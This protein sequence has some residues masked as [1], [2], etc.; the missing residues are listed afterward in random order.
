M[1]IKITEIIPRK[2]IAIDDLS[3]KIILVDAS[4]FMYQF[5]TTV[6]Q[7]DGTPLMDSHGN[8][9]S[10]LVGIFARTTKLMEKGL[11]LAYVFDGKS[12]KLKE[13]E[14][15]RRSSLK[16]EAQAKYKV[17]LK[18]KDIESMKKYAGRTARLTP[19]MVKECK[20]LIEALGLPVVQSPSEAEAQAA[21][22]VAKG[23]AYALATQDADALIFGATRVVRNLSILGKRKKVGQLKYE[24]VKPELI[25][26]APTLNSLGIDQD[27]L[28][29]L[30]MLV[31]TDFNVGGIHGIGPKKAIALV[32]E[33][34]KD[35][36]TLF[37][38]V[39][40]DEHFEHPWTEV[41]YTIKKIPTTD[42]YQ[43]K[44]T[45]PDVDKIQKIL[46]DKHDF[47]LER[48]LSAIKKIS[49]KSKDTTQRGLGEWS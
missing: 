18:K 35:F 31:G 43:L 11:K 34:G 37:E 5:L 22:M 44:W 45:S 41:F 15:E 20:Q 49:K 4:L 21:H 23:K 25:E 9:T 39:H 38:S 16:E 8:I 29:C 32:K 42:D 17:A 47:S 30:A 33:H 46:V 3:G 10:H 27:Q 12:P 7:R 19:E 40:W 48:V 28:I 24:T 36:D 13:T 26:L 14:V 2:E 6:R 1:G